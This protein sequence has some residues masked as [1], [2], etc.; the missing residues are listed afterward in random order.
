[1]IAMVLALAACDSSEQNDEAD[2]DE[3]SAAGMVAGGWEMADNEAAALP[4]EVQTAFDSAAGNLDGSELM[5]VA[6]MAEQ[7]VSGMNYM[8]LC[9]ATPAVQDPVPEYQVAVIYSDL[10]GN[11]EIKELEEFELEDYLED[12]DADIDDEELAGG[13]SVPEDLCGS[14][15]PGGARAAMEKALEGFTGSDIEPVALLATQTVSGTNYAFLCASTLTTEKP[16]T[17]IQ[18]VKVYEDLDGNAE[19]T[20]ISNVELEDFND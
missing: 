4:D 1:M 16:V 6:Y 3:S 18:V 7:T 2:S 11:A 5:P 15:I 13:W 9:K 10:D 17:G 19:I 8:I 14:A 20:G 12:D